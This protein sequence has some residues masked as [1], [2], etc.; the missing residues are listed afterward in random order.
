M[1]ISYDLRSKAYLMYFCRPLSPI[2]YIIGKSGVIWFF[3]SMITALPACALYLVAIMMSPD[4]SVIGDTWDIPLRIAAA[5]VVLVVPTSALALCYSSFTSESR[6]ASFS[7]FATWVM[8][9]VAYGQLTYAGVQMRPRRPRRGRRFGDGASEQLDESMPREIA[10]QGQEFL[11]Q[12]DFGPPNG[13][14]GPPRGRRGDFDL[15]RLDQIQAHQQSMFE[16]VDFD[17]WRLLSPYH[18]LGKVQE[19]VFGLESTD[20]SVIPALVM[21]IAITVVCWWIIR[22]RIVARLSV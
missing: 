20:G 3:L 9:G 14:F 15:E 4:L 6:Y 2:Q 17:K 19:W 1:L 22:R 13:D 7:W 10:V 11:A 5:T 16:G 12:R 21:L 8:G 18:T